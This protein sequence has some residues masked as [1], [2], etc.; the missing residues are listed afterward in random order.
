[1]KLKLLILSILF[2][3]ISYSQ[4][5]S[6]RATGFTDASRGVN[7]IVILNNNDVW[8]TAY[9]GSSAGANVQEFTKST[10]GGETWTAGAI[11]LGPATAGI[12]IGC[13]AAV[14][15]NT[16]WVT[17]FPNTAFDQK[18]I[19]K[20]TDGGTTWNK[21]DTALYTDGAAFPNIVYFWDANTGFCQ[22]DPTSGYF[23]IYTTT[24]GGT[25][26]VRTPSANIP[27]ELTGE[28]GYVRQ[29]EVVGNRLWY[30]TNKGRIYRSDDKGL[31]FEVFQS[32]LTDFGSATS[33]GNLSFWDANNGLL[34]SMQGGLWKTTDG[35]ETWNAITA[36]DANIFDIECVADSNSA[37]A[38]TRNA[39]G[40]TYSTFYSNDNGTTWS[41]VDNIQRIELE[42][43]NSLG[44]G[45][46][47]STNAT[48]GGI[49]KYT[50]TELP[51]STNDNTI[52]TFKAYPNPVKD[53]LTIE[54]VDTIS[55]VS[56]FNMLGQKVL[57]VN[58]NGNNANINM[59]SLNNGT[60]FAKVTINGA[61]ETM[62]IIK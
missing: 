49:F 8:A 62:K 42:F 29:I 54:G 7:Q 44:F 19:W 58:P 36:P 23:E 3:S 32:P 22:G 28:Y 12:G 17:G 13:I 24:D 33:S 43:K 9:D 56:I 46:A 26:W 14:D 35:G 20:T 6:E 57:N 25:N 34:A 53:I 5:W 1:M 38:T 59:N 40:D 48:T 52:T 16:A 51:A 18:G 61:T 10:D 30:T 39:A 50:G 41:M 27:N 55:N 47:F 11:N 4:F 60:Y 37:V 31:N 21:Q 2:T 45:G 15:S